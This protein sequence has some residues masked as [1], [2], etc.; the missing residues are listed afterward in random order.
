MNVQQLIIKGL[1][2]Q[3]FLHDFIVLPGFGGFVLKK[4]PAGFSAGGTL[5][6][7]AKVIGFNVQLK[8]NDGIMQS[9]LCE[10]L[11]CAAPEALH[12]LNEFS[13]YCQGVLNARRRLN[14]E[15]LGFFY[16]DLEGNICFEPRHDVNFL[17]SSFGLRPIAVKPLEQVNEPRRMTRADEPAPMPEPRQQAVRRSIRPIRYAVPLLITFAVVSVVLLLVTGQTFTGRLLSS[18]GSAAGPSTYSPIVYPELKLDQTV[19]EVQPYVADASG[20]ATI[21]TANG[22]PLFV[23]VNSETPQATGKKVQGTHHNKQSKGGF[24]IVAGCFSVHG[25]ALKMV[26]QLRANNIDAMIS[27]VLQRGMHVVS[28]A[29]FS[30]KDSASAL[31][32]QLKRE[33]PSAWIRWLR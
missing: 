25:N 28:I 8:Q 10:K 13:A 19:F 18:F 27:P 33:Y 6:P 31:L 11:R 3:L 23:N 26:K 4:A 12:Q 7:P 1:K 30:T 5:S 9:Y 22:R 32:Q 14:I 24:E 20:I 16:I 29:N 17:S 21:E 15:E 2:E